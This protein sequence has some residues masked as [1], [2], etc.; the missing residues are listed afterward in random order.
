MP[1]KY[2]SRQPPQEEDAAADP[3][4]DL[5][6]ALPR[7]TVLKPAT[8]D[9]NAKNEFN[10]RQAGDIIIRTTKERKRIPEDYMPIDTGNFDE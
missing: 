7:D 5:L 6:R 9:Q 4:G 2:A 8:A 1:R 3:G 10:H